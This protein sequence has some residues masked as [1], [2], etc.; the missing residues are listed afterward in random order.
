MSTAP[1]VWNRFA[2]GW[3]LGF[4]AFMVVAVI[5]LVTAT[6]LSAAQRNLALVCIAAIVLAFLTFRPDMHVPGRGRPEIAYLL[7]VILATG[8]ACGTDSSL[9]LL[10]CIVFPQV[11]LFS[12]DHRTGVVLT[13]L[14]GLAATLGFMTGGGWTAEN[15]GHTLPI[16]VLSTVFSG[17]FGLWIQGV[18]DQSA[19]RSQ[20]IEQLEQTRAELGR[21]HHTQGVQA[22]RERL[23]REIHD[24]LAQG[25]TSIVML[26]QVA[27]AALPGEGSALDGKLALIESVARENLGEA[28]SLVAAFSPVG[29]DGSTLA[30]AVR[31]LA[32]RFG[33]E[34]GI[35]T[36]VSVTGDLTGLTR[37]REV[38][39]LRA[40]QEGLA[41]VRRHAGARSVSVRLI[42]TA[43][44]AM[45]EISDDGKGFTM[46]DEVAPRGFGL[47][48]MRDR[49]RAGGGGLE[50]ASTPGRG[51][52]ITVRVPRDVTG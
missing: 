38:V 11:W 13:G 8:V 21:A 37:D 43:Q 16:M 22:E 24:T 17:A 50:V 36:D 28:R 32:G 46:E 49:A 15:A 19:E 33:P 30:D 1:H 29:L 52:T 47:T 7:T 27:R 31:R 35:A 45:I 12:P 44:H 10:L 9:A 18:I 40:T 25:F 20:L 48:G 51:T 5:R 23:A 26:A 41:N 3:G 4:A 14:L 42:G 39:L 2:R 6:D 34:T